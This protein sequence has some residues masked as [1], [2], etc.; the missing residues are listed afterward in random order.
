MKVLV[1]A[2]VALVAPAAVA[3]AVTDYAISPIV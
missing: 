2:L 3:H 1:A